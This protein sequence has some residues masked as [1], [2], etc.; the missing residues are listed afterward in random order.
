MRLLALTGRAVLVLSVS[1]CAL[2]ASNQ[3]LGNAAQSA[4]SCLIH[5]AQ[6]LD[7]Q[8]SDAIAVAYGLLGACDSEIRQAEAI[9][10][11]GLGFEGHQT[12]K[13]RLNEYFLKAATE[14]VLKERSLRTQ[15]SK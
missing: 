5:A 2:P 12:V 10:A 13:R 8:K 6:N 11:Q 3:E 4:T 1:G 7:D 15:R 9:T 14:I